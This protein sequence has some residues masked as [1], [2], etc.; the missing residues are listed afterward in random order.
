MAS[1]P[2]L[3]VHVLLNGEEHFFRDPPGN[4]RW[5]T[6]SVKDLNGPMGEIER[7]HFRTG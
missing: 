1:P 3:T 2:D 6:Q 7:K 4:L 5:L